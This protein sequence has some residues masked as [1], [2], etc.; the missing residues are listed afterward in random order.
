[1]VLVLYPS[2]QERAQAEVDA[3][4]GRERLPEFDDRPH[5]PYIDAICRELLRWRMVTPMGVSFLFAFVF[6]EAHI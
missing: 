3:I 1:M 4:V 2:V 5:M 6:L